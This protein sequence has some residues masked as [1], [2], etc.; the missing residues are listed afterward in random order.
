[1][2][3][4]ILTEQTI[5]TKITLEGEKNEEQKII[6]RVYLNNKLISEDILAVI[7][8]YAYAEVKPIH[9]STEQ[10]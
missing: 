1:M 2:P 10:D 5:V 6:K 9:K 4:I 3:T 8:F 7:P